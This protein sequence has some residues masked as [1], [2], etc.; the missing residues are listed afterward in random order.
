MATT[1]SKRRLDKLRN[2]GI[3]A[4]IDAGK[5]T[6]TE[7]F[8]FYSHKIHR[9]GEVHEG[10]ATMDFMPEEQERGITISSACT[11]SFWNDHTLNL[12]DTPG[13][14]DF[15]IEVERSLR[16]LDG[17]VGVFCGV[18]GVE[19]QSETVWRQ[20]ERFHVPKLA[21]VNKMDRLGADF[22]AVLDAIHT[23][24][25][26]TVLPITIPIGS[27]QDFEGVIDVMT[28]ERLAFDTESMGEQVGRYPLTDEERELAEPWRERFFETLSDVDEAVME[29]YL[30][31]DPVPLET[32][33]HAVRRATLGLKLV[34][35]YSGSAL[36]NIGVQPV[37]DGV[38]DFLPSPMEAVPPVGRDPNTGRE[39][40][41]EPN[42]DDPMVALVFKVSMV[43]G[44]RQTFLRIYAGTL[45]VGEIVRNV[46]QG[47]DERVARLFRVHADHREKIEKAAAGDIVVLAGMK[48]ARTG[49]T[50]TAAGRQIVLESIEAY[51]PVISVAIEPRNSSEADKL[52]EVLQKSLAED[53]T[54]TLVQDED[55]GQRIL[56]GMGELHL[57]VVLDRLRREYGV[58]PRVGKPQVVHQET[59]TRTAEAWGEFHR[60]LGEI[61][62]FG[63]VQ[64]RVEPL[65][66]GAGRQVRL[67]VSSE[68]WPEQWLA[69]AEDGVSDALQSG[70]IKGYAVHDVRVTIIGMERKE[71]ESTPAGY[72]MA[73][74]QAVREGLT[75]A[76]PTLLEPIMRVEI[77]VPEEYVGEAVGLLGSLNARV[78]DID[79]AGKGMK[80]VR[81][82]AA[83]R[84]LF[85]FSTTLRS[86][87][88]GRAGLSISFARFDTL[89]T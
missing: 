84:A 8:L 83:M 14:V 66:R 25:G 4:H 80:V 3:I 46:T 30:S 26:A 73:A 18:G 27:G 81:G 82:L 9:M 59:V 38:C 24:L 31:G 29:A 87:T 19:P 41:I 53:P 67:G 28:M 54:L 60:E 72:H 1:V 32:L 12:I 56:S 10:T 65:E 75:S 50:L 85:G 15:T 37:F 40:V 70:V 5:T 58:E 36:K 71:G 7:R 22:E 21:F 34:P 89:A 6:L 11:T 88:Q 51:Q 49:D 57:E 42:F 62:H 20:S 48:L 55:T 76:G 44:R 68:D 16:V 69:A 77:S 63:R 23:K 35:V 74:A 39:W 45:S 17:A 13:H 86:A 64:V 78:E 79:D 33:K 2:I 52:D 61:M 47:Q 43:G